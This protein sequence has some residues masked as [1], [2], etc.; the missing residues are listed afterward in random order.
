VL[1]VPHNNLQQTTIEDNMG[2]VG[3]VIKDHVK[4]IDKIGLFT[5]DD[6]F[7]IGCLGL[8]KAENTY[9]PDAKFSTYAYILIRNEIFSALEYATIRRR[10]EIVMDDATG[11][12]PPEDGFSEIT[13]IEDLLDAAKNRATGVVAKGID[14]IRMMADGYT[15]REIGELMGGV[16]ANN[17]TAWISKA[18]VFLKGDPNII[19]LRDAI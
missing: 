2:L 1:I 5:Y 17:I 8:I 14:A 15:C 3:A 4:D 10:H 19:A 18:R 13:D 7:Q 9:K 12:M 16:S 11:L 6:L